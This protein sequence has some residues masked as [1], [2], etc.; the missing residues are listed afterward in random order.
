[1]GFN[2]RQVAQTNNVASL[3]AASPSGSTVDVTK[4]WTAVDCTAGTATVVM[5]AG[6]DIGQECWLVLIAIGLNNGVTLSGS[7][8]GSVTPTLTTLG[9]VVCLVWGGTTWIVAKTVPT[10]PTPSAP[11][12]LVRHFTGSD[13]TGPC[14]L[15]GGG[16]PQGSTVVLI[17]GAAT[18]TVLTNI[19]GSPAWP[20]WNDSFEST[21]STANSIEQVSSEDLSGHHFTV[22]LVQ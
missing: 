22:L 3:V 12:F 15:S 2:Q 1:M 18:T 21:L 20:D 14:A 5:P 10:N 9:Q 13:D 7:F 19:E 4:R 6:T 16:A 11:N 8:E 17:L